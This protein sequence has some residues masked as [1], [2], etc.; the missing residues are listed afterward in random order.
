MEENS[1][2]YIHQSE[3][4]LYLVIRWRLDE[5]TEEGVGRQGRSGV[6]RR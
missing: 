4:K 1:L 3:I 6:K 2:K 5:R